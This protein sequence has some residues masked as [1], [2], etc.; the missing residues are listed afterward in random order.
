[1]TTSVIDRDV[2][3]VGRESKRARPPLKRLLVLTESRGN[4]AEFEGN[5]RPFAVA[6][7]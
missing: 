2:A 3:S 5:A 4:I 7:R 1:M 6:P